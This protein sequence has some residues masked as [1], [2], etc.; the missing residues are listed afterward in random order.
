MSLLVILAME[1][2]PS[3]KIIQKIESGD[4][5]VRNQSGKVLNAPKKPKAEK[6]LIQTEGE[7]H[8]ADDAKAG[9]E[10]PDVTQKKTKKMDKKAEKLKEKPKA[11]PKPVFPAERKIN[12]YGFIGLT[13][14]MCKEMGLPLYTG[15]REK[16]KG[17]PKLKRDIPITFAAFNEKTRELTVKIGK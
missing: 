3:E 10:A 5:K 7:A 17:V 6:S 15:E 14:A 8:E 13:V 1:M 4:V 12:K 16:G 11:E 9:T 2:E